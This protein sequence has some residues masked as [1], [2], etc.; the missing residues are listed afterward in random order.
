MIGYYNY[1]VILTYLSLLSAIFGT[2]LAFNGQS[3]YALI[4]LFMCGAFDAF[5]GIVARSK[6]DRTVEEKKFGIQIDS[7]VDMF[8]F[9]VFPTFIAYAMGLKGIGWF[10]VFSLY[11]I[12]AVS[13]LGYFNVSEE[14]RQQQ[15]TE[16]RKYYQGLPVTVSA[17]IFPTIYL[18]LTMLNLSSSTFLMVYGASML[19]V[20]VAFVTDFKVFKPGLKGI[21]AMGVV[22]IAVMIGLLML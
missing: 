11:S 4:C 21:L 13:R 3:K 7:L 1:T 19:V 2:Q 20:A 8:S 15:T 18:I 22:G 17:L 16:K 5:D 6:K 10:V 12:G 9:G 14:M